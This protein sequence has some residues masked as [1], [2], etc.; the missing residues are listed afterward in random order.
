MFQT[1][2]ASD[3]SEFSLLRSAGQLL[4]DLARDVLAVVLGR[5]SG[6]LDGGKFLTELS[7]HINR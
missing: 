6:H 5:T 1:R 4:D 2:A 3:I 7:E